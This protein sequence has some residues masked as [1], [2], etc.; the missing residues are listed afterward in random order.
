MCGLLGGYRSGYRTGYNSGQQD[1]YDRNLVSETYGTSH[2]IWPDLTGEE[3]AKAVHP[4]IELIQSTIASEI[5]DAAATGA[6][7]RDFES[8]QS[9][10]ITAPGAVQ[11]EIRQL[12]RQLGDL[13]SRKSAKNMPL[14]STMQSLASRGIS[15]T[16]TFHFAVPK[17]SQLA[18]QWFEEYYA[19]GVDCVSE[20]WGRPTYAG[21]CT[22][23][24]FPKWSLDQ[25]IAIWPRG[26]GLAYLALQRQGDG[27]LHLIAGWRK[28]S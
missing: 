17:S 6:E 20:S 16:T 7:I 10:V 13:Q 11:R 22:D 12:F 5:W 2:V 23:P 15:G 9:L 24:G 27:Q 28:E 1:Y 21:L 19:A 4:L 18:H 25:R 26:P 14:I 8:G 3:R